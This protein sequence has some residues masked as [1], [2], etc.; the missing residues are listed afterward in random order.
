MWTLLVCREYFVGPALAVLVA[1]SMSRKALAADAR[2]TLNRCAI[3]RSSLLSRHPHV[4]RCWNR[5]SLDVAQLI[6]PRLQSL[7][8]VM[9]VCLHVAASRVHRAILQP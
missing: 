6:P 9:L 4:A 1:V 7:A 2:G 3:A 8:R 5:L